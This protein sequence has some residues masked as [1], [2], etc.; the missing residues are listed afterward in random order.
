MKTVFSRW[1][2]IGLLGAASA[3]AQAQ[4]AP[5]AAP[6]AEPAAAQA[7]AVDPAK[8]PPADFVAPAEPKAD[9]SNAARGKSQPGNNAPFWR[10]VRE[11]GEVA[12]ITNLP[13]VEKGVLIQRF[14]I[15]T[16]YAFG[17]NVLSSL[18]INYVMRKFF[19][20]KG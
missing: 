14:G 5:V 13:G 8:G 15:E 11:S 1:L 10:S 3:L 7:V 2:A 18:A 4:T 16:T 19:V 20:F 9:D 12:G 17:A 6:V